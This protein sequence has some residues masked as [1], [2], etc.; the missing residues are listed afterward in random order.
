MSTRAVLPPVPRKGL[1]ERWYGEGPLHLLLLAATFCLAGYAGVRLLAGDAFGIALWFVGAALVHDL[2]FVPAYSL[3][4]RAVRRSLGPWSGRINFVRVPALLSGLLLL[5]WFP[6]ITRRTERYE[7]ASGLS[8]D[9][10]LGNWLL[11]TA[12]LFAASAL[13][14]VVRALWLRRR[15]TKGRL[16]DSHR[17]TGRQSGGRA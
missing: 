12:A 4:D 15:D 11:I 13:W 16:S 5:T 14:F 10:F 1:L 6:L 9:S 2:V 7:P 8:P 17:S 3:L